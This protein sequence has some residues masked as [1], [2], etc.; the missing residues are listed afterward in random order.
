[1]EQKG[2]EFTLQ[3]IRYRDKNRNA[4]VKK[5]LRASRGNYVGVI[6]VVAPW[7]TFVSNLKPMCFLRGA[8]TSRNTTGMQ[9]P[10]QQGGLSNRE[11]LC[12]ATHRT[13]HN[14]TFGKA[15]PVPEASNKSQAGNSSPV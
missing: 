7:H 10:Q 5:S 9:H 3:S 11:G 8:K 12:Q 6:H 2:R 4:E 14:P 13:L 15:E 1:M